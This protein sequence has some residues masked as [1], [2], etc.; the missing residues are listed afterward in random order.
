MKI[1][2]INA[3]SQQL[4]IRKLEI[5]KTS[6][7]KDCIIYAGYDYIFH[8][9]GKNAIYYTCRR[10]CGGR[11]KFSNTEF[12]I[13]VKHLET[14]KPI[15]ND[16]LSLTSDFQGPSMKLPVQD[17]SLSLTSDFQGPSMKLPVQDDSLSLTSDFQGPSMKLPV[18]AD[19]ALLMDASTQTNI[20][21]F[22]PTSNVCTAECQTLNLQVLDITNS[23]IMN[24]EVMEEIDAHNRIINSPT[25]IQNNQY[26][27]ITSKNNKKMIYYNKYLY[28]HDFGDLYYK[29]RK[30]TC[31]GRGKFGSHFT[32]TQT[33]NHLDDEEYYHF[34]VTINLLKDQINIDTHLSILKIYQK[35]MRTRKLDLYCINHPKTLPTF[36]AVKSIMG[37][38]VQSTRPSFPI[39][40]S[41][42]IL[43][44]EHKLTID[45]RQF[46]LFN[47]EDNK[48]FIFTT[49]KLLS[50]LCL[51]EK[52]FLDGTFN[53]SPKLFKQFYT[54]SI[55]INHTLII[56]V[57]ILLP[58]KY[59]NTYLNMFLLLKIIVYL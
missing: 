44:D 13:T 25:I 42:I 56:C 57:Y 5:K 59:K 2:E 1:Q 19:N 30:N 26:S 32:V 28:S 18:Q 50:R 46:L 14:C 27:F 15:Q 22:S 41:S 31:K 43:H 45:R 58:D 47:S 38:V 39:N 33:H 7:N 37:R 10:R 12:S 53:A 9:Y 35:V 4:S 29:C 24:P 8:K 21:L 16:S 23:P 40:N 51:A 52:I 55:L 11:A 49:Y 3:K 20:S 6:K 34:L 48:I 54:I 17:D 36:L